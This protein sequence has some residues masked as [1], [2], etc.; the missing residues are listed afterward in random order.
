MRGECNGNTR[1][2]PSPYRYPAHGETFVQAAALAANHDA[3]KYLDPFLVAFHH[4]RVHAYAVAD[5]KRRDIT[6]LLF[7]LNNIDGLVHKLVASARGCGRTI[8]SR[9]AEIANAIASLK[10]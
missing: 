6:F 10:R 9:I 8:S 3:G 1:S 4:P 2:T 5:R 7:F